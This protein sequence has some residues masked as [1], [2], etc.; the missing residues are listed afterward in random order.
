M[1]YV[2]SAS[3]DEYLMHVANVVIHNAE[4]NTSQLWRSRDSLTRIIPEEASKVLRRCNM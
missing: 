3:N 2:T 4:D 1:S